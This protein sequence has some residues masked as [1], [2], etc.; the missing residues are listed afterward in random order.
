MNVSPSAMTKHLSLLTRPR[1]LLTRLIQHVVQRRPST[2]CRQLVRDHLRKLAVREE[3][4]VYTQ[5]G[6]T[7]NASP[8]EYSSYGIFFFGDYDPQMTD[9]IRTHL[10]PGDVAM[11]LG[12]DRGWFTLLM[13]QCVGPTGKVHSFEA[14]PPNVAKVQHNLALNGIEH[15]TVNPVAISD[16]PGHVYFE[17]PSDAVTKH[18]G[19]LNDCSGVGYVADGPGQGRLEVPA[20]TLDDY[21]EQVGLDR[22]DLVKIDIEG[23]EV[24]ALAGARRTLERFRP[25][26]AIEYNRTTLERAGTS[27]HELDRLLDELG[28]GRY[29]LHYHLVPLDLARYD[30]APDHGAVLNVY[31]LPR[32]AARSAA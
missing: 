10:R 6:F 15:V 3:L 25:V 1:L 5:A 30:G 9:F 22:L 23:A 14:Y 7:M 18:I 24:A 29:C 20:I 26:I 17:P 32:Q 8:R 13:A 27:W 4:P 21:A 2:R 16:K 11:D 19:F 31:C 28:Y 12:T